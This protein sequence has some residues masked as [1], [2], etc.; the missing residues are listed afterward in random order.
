[1]YAMAWNGYTQHTVRNTRLTNFGDTVFIGEL[2]IRGE[3]PKRK[4]KRIDKYERKG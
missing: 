2:I 1:M 4:K 3:S